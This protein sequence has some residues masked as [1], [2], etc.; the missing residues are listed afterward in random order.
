MALAAGMLFLRQRGAAAARAGGQA[1]PAAARDRRVLRRQR[2]AGGPPMI[3]YRRGTRRPGGR[4]SLLTAAW[5]GSALTAAFALIGLVVI[6]GVPGSPGLALRADVYN[7]MTGVGSTASAVTVNWTSG[8]LDSS[9]QPITSTT[10]STDGGPELNPNSDRAAGTG[11]LSFMTA[12]SRTCRSRSARP[13]TSGSR[14]SPSAGPGAEAPPGPSPQFDFL[15][16]ME[17]YGDSDSGPSPEG[18]EFGS[19]GLLGG[20]PV[21]ASVGDR[22]G[23]LCGTATTPGAVAPSTTNPPDAEQT[24]GDPSYGCDPFEPAAESTSHCDP[25]SGLPVYRTCPGGSFYVPFVPANDPHQPGL[26]ANQPDF[27]VRPVQH[28]R[29]A[30]RAL[31]RGRDRAASVRDAY[32]EPVSRTGLRRAGEQRPGPQLLARHRAARQLRAERVRGVPQRLWPL[33]RGQV[34]RQLA[35]ER[36]QLGPAHPDPPRLRA[37]GGRLPAYRPARRRWSAPRSPTGR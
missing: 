27:P 9:N 34:H 6:T 11:S 22:G 23:Y 32:R 33:L 14:A 31:E 5:W 13:R 3:A 1:Q 24:P 37:A 26:R 21:N 15:Q 2:L 36:L 7:Q 29:G 30:V 18:C 19:S 12:S 20:N 10:A 28:Q 25:T 8:L 35:A 4:S 16:M 17:C